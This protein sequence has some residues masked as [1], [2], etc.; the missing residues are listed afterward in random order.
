M[1]EI[2]EHEEITVHNGWKVTC[3]VLIDRLPLEVIERPEFATRFEKFKKE[4]MERTGNN[5]TVDQEIVFMRLPFHFLKTPEQ[6]AHERAL[7]ESLGKTATQK[8]GARSEI[9]MLLM[10]E[11]I[12]V[13]DDDEEVAFS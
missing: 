5:N 6:R 4:W 12:E 2:P 13:A 11:G 7:E 3:S 10:Q 1:E 8:L 9:D